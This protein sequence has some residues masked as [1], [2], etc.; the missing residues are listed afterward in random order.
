MDA[1]AETMI[2]IQG[3]LDKN[4]P[5][6]YTHYTRPYLNVNLE[7]RNK[8]GMKLIPLTLGDMEWCVQG[9]GGFGVTYL[10]DDLEQNASALSA[11]YALIVYV[12]G[13]QSKF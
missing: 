3:K 8:I 13:M 11:V 5:W 4:G 10:Y 12:G 6:R 9:G 2:L 1:Y 7:V